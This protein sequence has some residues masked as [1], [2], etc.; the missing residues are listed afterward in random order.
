MTKRNMLLSLAAG[1][2]GDMVFYRAGGEQR[3]RTR[4]IPKN[5][6]TIA[7]MNQRLKML[8]PSCMYAQLAAVLKS[9]FTERNVNQSSANKFMSESVK[10]LPWYISKGMKEAGFCVPFNAKVAA[11]NLGVAVKSNVLPIYIEGGETVKQAAAYDCL[12]DVT[13]DLRNEMLPV[14]VPKA[15]FDSYIDSGLFGAALRSALKIAVP[16]NFIITV[17]AGAPSIIDEELGNE[18][19]KLGYRQYIV[20]GN[21]V[22]VAYFGCAEATDFTYLH[23]AKQQA[24]GLAY[25][26]YAGKADENG[27]EVAKV[28]TAIIVSFEEDGKLK[29]TSSSFPG[30]KESGSNPARNYLRFYKEG[31]SIYVQTMEEYGYSAGTAL[32][33]QVLNT[34]EEPDNG[35]DDDNGGFEE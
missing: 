32:D 2:L 3:T 15:G 31:G 23:T 14:P 19:W 8:N 29:V 20:R 17:I 5:P 18:G 16:E 28:P 27:V 12:F 24:A 30:E 11:G 6:K 1:K 25:K 26:M 13:A 22:S 4:V 9:S 33:S 34:T 35:E 7:Q 10:A 21:E